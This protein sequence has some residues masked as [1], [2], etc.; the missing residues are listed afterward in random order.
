MSATELPVFLWE[1]NGARYDE[2]DM[3][4]GLFR[5]FYLERVSLSIS[6]YRYS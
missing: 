1:D 6:R 3:Y 4:L 5:G 2:E